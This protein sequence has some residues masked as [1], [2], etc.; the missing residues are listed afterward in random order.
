LEAEKQAI[1]NISYVISK[2]NQEAQDV[3]SEFTLI[4]HPYK[5][6]Y[7]EYDIAVQTLIDGLSDSIEIIDLRKIFMN[8]FSY[9]QFESL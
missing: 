2:F 5:S 4:V 7:T 8:E 6:N 3:G 1:T 9:Q